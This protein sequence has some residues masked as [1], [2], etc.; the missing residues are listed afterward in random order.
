FGAMKQ[1]GDVPQGGPAYASGN[2]EAFAASSLSS[3]PQYHALAVLEMMEAL[4]R[5]NV[6]TYAIDPRGAV[7]AGDLASECFPAPSPGNDPCVDDS[8]GPNDWMSPVRQAQ[9]GLVETA[10]ATGGF[11][12]TNTDDYSGGLSRIL[13]DLDHYYLIGF[14]PSD[15][16]GKGY[17]A[18]NV[19]IAGHPDSTLRYRRGCMG[20]AAAPAPPDADPMTS[21]SSSILPNPDLP[22]RLTAI[23]TPG[24]SRSAHVTLGLEVTV[25]SRSLLEADGKFRDTLKYEVLVVDEKKAKVRSIGG[26]EGRL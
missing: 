2:L 21:L 13:D 26:L 10:V 1:P 22:M 19:Q 11:A 16:N 25:P 17:R 23:A 15:P 18:L 5:A 6:A 20:G 9:H 24:P 14:Y 8:A 3:V 7:K 4:R 12:V